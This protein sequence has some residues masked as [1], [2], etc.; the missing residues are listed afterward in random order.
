MFDV[1]LRIRCVPAPIRAVSTDQTTDAQIDFLTGRVQWLCDGT[2]MKAAIIPN[3]NFFWVSPI[4]MILLTKKPT[5]TIKDWVGFAFR[6][7]VITLPVQ[8]GDHVYHRI[9]ASLDRTIS[10]VKPNSKTAL[11]PLQ[12]NCNQ[13]IQL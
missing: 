11:K 12:I 6:S 2:V 3:Y 13:I 8:L 9:N 7:P 1:C 5:S 10:V 4:S